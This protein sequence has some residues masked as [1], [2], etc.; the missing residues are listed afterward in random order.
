MSLHTKAKGCS[1]YPPQH[2]RTN[3]QQLFNMNIRASNVRMFQYV[4][5]S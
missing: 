4:Q 2:P 3:K 1:Y 5:V